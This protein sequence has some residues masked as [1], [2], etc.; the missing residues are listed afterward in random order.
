VDDPEKMA[1]PRHNKKLNVVFVDMHVERLTLDK[2]AHKTA[3]N[4]ECPNAGCNRLWHPRRLRD[5]QGNIRLIPY[6]WE[7]WK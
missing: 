3:G 7:I 5:S 6:D 2:I 4:G 1:A